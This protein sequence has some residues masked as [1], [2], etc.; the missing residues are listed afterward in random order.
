M[1]AQK[2]C[3]PPL[4]EPAA[5]ARREE[6]NCR[7]LV[8]LQGVD[9]QGV[10]LPN[11]MTNETVSTTTSPWRRIATP[12]APASRRLNSR[13]GPDR[14]LTKIRIVQDDA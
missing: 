12:D 2:N 13:P 14:A 5:L 8:N 9:D 3:A 11:F 10:V 1:I 4:P 7:R 6:P